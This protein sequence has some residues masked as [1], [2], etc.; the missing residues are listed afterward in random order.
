[1]THDHH[2]DSAGV[3]WEGRSFQP[4]PHAGDS[5]ETPPDVASALA[6]W[7]NGTGT[8]SA[9]V[10]AFAANRFLIPLVAHA[11]DDFDADN[12]V[13]EDKVQE[14]SVVT[15]AGP[16]GEKVI[17]VF[18]SAAAMKTWNAEARP[19]PIEAQRVALA[20]ASEHTDRIVVNPGTDSMVIR[21]PALWAIA[22]GVGYRAPW[23]SAEFL[24]DAMI[25]L[26]DIAHLEDVLVTAGDS[27]SSGEGAD[28]VLG[29][30]VA[31]GL[32]PEEMRS[33][34]AEVQELIAGDE[35][36]RLHV[37]ALRITVSRAPA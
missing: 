29:L 24:A 3:P 2:T 19:I 28:V 8:Y 35:N 36:F 12:P 17:P 1:M 21:R 6:A 22:Q 23:E 34:L 30:T 26:G 16:N 27:L 32:E 18:T 9:L 7:R 14:L 37:D 15:V 20:A 31:A 13:M 10:A 11:G 4:N 33:V 25:L 5:G